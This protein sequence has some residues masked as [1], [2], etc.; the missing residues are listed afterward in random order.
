MEE[1]KKRITAYWARRADGFE[2][3]RLREFESPKRE[4]WLQEIKK[5]LPDKKPLKVLDIGTGT[6]FF[7]CLM[8]AE[9]HEVIGIDLTPDMVKHA[10]HMAH[11][12]NYDVS[13]A[14]MDAEAPDFAPESFD[15]LL[16][17]NLTWTLPNIKKAYREWYKLLKSGGVL[18]N[19]DA[20]YYAELDKEKAI[21]L[22]R[23]HAHMSLSD[24][25][26][27]ENEALTRIIGEH[28]PARP[29]WDFQLLMEAGFERIYVDTGAYKRIYK[30]VDEFYNPASLFVIAAFK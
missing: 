1:I 23:M 15:V 30:D 7:S 18:I 27:Q 20:D 6:G 29:H 24:A 17:R 14:V 26:M 4:I 19:F 8:A 13:F 3:Q 25:M 11:L 5:Y 10:G 9:G 28:Q 12:L 21:E 16:T 22:P 2:V